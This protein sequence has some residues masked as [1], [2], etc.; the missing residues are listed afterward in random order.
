MEVTLF[1]S[2]IVILLLLTY[3]IVSKVSYKPEPPQQPIVEK[4]VVFAYP[5]WRD[6]WHGFRRRWGWY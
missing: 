1:I 3:I 6:H 4:R 5:T 2:I